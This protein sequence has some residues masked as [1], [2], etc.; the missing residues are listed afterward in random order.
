MDEVF[1]DTP[2]EHL[3]TKVYVDETSDP[4][5]LDVTCCES[6]CRENYKIGFTILITSV[7]IRKV[8]TFVER[9]LYYNDCEQKF[10]LA[11]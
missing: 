4:F 9:Y 11:S 10:L 7:H 5:I 8:F 6:S 1:K 2:G 3:F